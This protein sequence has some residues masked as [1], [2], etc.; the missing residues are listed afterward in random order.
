MQHYGT[1][2]R[3]LDWTESALVAFYFAVSSQHS[4]DAEVWA[5]Y[6]QALNAITFDDRELS[7]ID[8]DEAVQSLAAEAFSR[9]DGV[10]ALRRRSRLL[11]S[12][13]YPIAFFPVRSW[14]RMTA[15]LSAFT[16][17]P[18]PVKGTTIPELMAQDHLI[19]YRIPSDRKPILQEALRCMGINEMSLFP[20]LEGLSRWI[21][22]ELVPPPP[23]VV[24]LQIGRRLSDPDLWDAIPHENRGSLGSRVPRL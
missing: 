7:S 2:T 11:T 1:P 18:V 24:D 19:R 17:H 13:E 6:P 12:G 9:S 10:A 20:D 22:N 15:Q 16:I 5:F 8:I 23:G 4:H 14:E 21:R 3:L